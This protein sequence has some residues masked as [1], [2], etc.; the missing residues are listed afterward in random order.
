AWA[1]GPRTYLGLGVPGFPNLFLI[2]G[3]GS[4]SVLT[5]MVTS[6]EHH[7]DWIS[8]CLDHLRSHGYDTIE[9]NAEAAEE[10]VAYV[11]AVAGVTLYTTCNS[12]YLG[13]NIPGKPRVFMPLFG[14]APYVDTCADIAADG[15]RGF[16]LEGRPT[17]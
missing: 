16:N 2:T 3:P 12:W 14:F 8:D 10:W 13:A 7:V 15:Y 6:I 5:N 4:P 1:A 17:P 11:N 9:P